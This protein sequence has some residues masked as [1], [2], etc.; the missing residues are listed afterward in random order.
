MNKLFLGLGV[1]AFVLVAWFLVGTPG[2]GRLFP[3]Q[4]K[5]DKTSIEVKTD[6]KAAKSLS[7]ASGNAGVTG[8]ADV[9]Q[10][11]RVPADSKSGSG[12]QSSRQSSGNDS[13]GAGTAGKDTT[14]S[15]NDT[16][17]MA[18]E[19]KIEKTAEGTGDQVTK[20]GDTITVNYTGTLTDGTKFD[21]SLNPGRTPF[22]FTVGAGQVI[23]GWDQGLLDMKVGEKRKL[24]IP[25]SLGYGERGQGPIPA[26]ATLIFDV[27]LLSIK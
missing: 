13:S 4:S 20:K 22:S 27:E 21:S 15:T 6:G 26:N 18:T 2:M 3:D 8:V 12:G 1:V 5:G 16:N 19:L 10:D 24:T 23:K 17:A 11:S 14:S 9:G 25:A 7:A